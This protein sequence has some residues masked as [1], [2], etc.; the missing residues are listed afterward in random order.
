[1]AAISKSGDFVSVSFPETTAGK[2]LGYILSILKNAPPTLQITKGGM[3]DA[4]RSDDNKD[5]IW[6][7]VAFLFGPSTDDKK[8]T[9]L[10]CSPDRLVQ[11][12]FHANHQRPF[13][14]VLTKKLHL[15]EN[16]Y[17]TA[18]AP[19][20]NVVCEDNNLYLIQ[21]DGSADRIVQY[22]DTLVTASV[23]GALPHFTDQ[24]LVCTRRSEAPE[25]VVNNNE[26]D[27]FQQVDDWVAATLTQIGVL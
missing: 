11:L 17:V 9:S 21:P 23:L 6:F 4:L 1:M 24:L 2:P 18:I 19:H 8:W 13:S 7:A 12:A 26:D 22:N 25:L 15:A 5:D 20:H 16:S 10:K 3:L 27:V 14:I